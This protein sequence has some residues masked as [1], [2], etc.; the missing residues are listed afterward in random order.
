MREIEHAHDVEGLLTRD[1]RTD[2]QSVRIL[3]WYLITTE[4]ICTDQMPRYYACV[5]IIGI[6]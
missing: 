6:G 3:S 1:P 2:G 5:L 4:D